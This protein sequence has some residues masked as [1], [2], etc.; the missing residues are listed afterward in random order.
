MDGRGSSGIT[1]GTLEETRSI[2]KEIAKRLIPGSVVALHGDLGAGKTTLASFLIEELTKTPNR[3]ISSPTFTYLHI[4]QG[5]CP[6]FHFDLYRIANRATFI[7][8]GFL[9]QLEEEGISIIEWPEIIED[10]LPRDTL[11]VH[12]KH[13]GENRREIHVH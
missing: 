7:Q 6:V 2:A 12:L 5:E 1:S 13:L 8:M 9:D 11:H 4:Y 10:L 3:E